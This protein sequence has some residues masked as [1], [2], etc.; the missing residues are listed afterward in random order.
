MLSSGL[1]FY[2]PEREVLVLRDGCS[3]PQKG[4][5]ERLR[6]RKPK[7]SFFERMYI[8][9]LG[10][11]ADGLERM[12]LPLSRPVICEQSGG[13]IKHPEVLL[14]LRKEPLSPKEL[15]TLKKANITVITIDPRDAE[16]YRCLVARPV[17]STR[18]KRALR[19][20]VTNRNRVLDVVR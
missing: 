7:K 16:E 13:S 15:N 6:R 9:I 11:I 18:R 2:D 3:L 17:K 20:A 10:S 5:E 4:K 12:R 1:R 19:S 14:I 8:G